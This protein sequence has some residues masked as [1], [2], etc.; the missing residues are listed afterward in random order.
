MSYSCFKIIY[1]VVPQLCV[2]LLCSG[3][4]HEAIN[5]QGYL[6]T[7]ICGSLDIMYDTNGHRICSES[8]RRK[9]SCGK[10]PRETKATNKHVKSI[11]KNKVSVRKKHHCRGKC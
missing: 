3:Y 11:N 2:F 9:K 7:N 4:D 6:W 1:I 5:G 10:I 8:F